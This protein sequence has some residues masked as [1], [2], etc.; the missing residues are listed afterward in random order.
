MDM[1]TPEGQALSLMLLLRIR[2]HG[3]CFNA[4]QCSSWVWIGRKQIG[5]SADEPLGD[6]TVPSV[7]E[8]NTL[9]AHTILL[10]RIATVISVH[11]V[12]EQ[13][14]SSLF[15]HTPNMRDIIKTSGANRSYFK[16][17]SF[18]HSMPKGTILIGNAPWISG[19]AAL[20]AAQ[21]AATEQA[22]KLAEAATG[23]T[24]AKSGA[25]LKRPALKRPAAAAASAA[26]TV[27]LVQKGSVLKNVVTGTKG[28][29]KASQEYPVRFALRVVQQQ[30]PN[31]R[32]IQMQ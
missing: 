32:L 11:W 2:R 16:M 21:S 25:V 23:A 1:T 10:A 26:Y 18:R 12:V 9:N 15:F 20:A 17:G 3:L 24:G 7:R 14:A 29:L 8:G 6:T 13:P 19:F 27:R 5:R 31:N 22:E 28:T 30:F 4:A